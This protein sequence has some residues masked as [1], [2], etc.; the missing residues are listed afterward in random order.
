MKLV[1][2]SLVV[3]LSA[4][5]LAHC[6]LTSEAI[7]ITEGFSPSDAGGSP[8]ARGW[9]TTGFTNIFSWN[10][11]SQYLDVF[12]DSSKQNS[13]FYHP[14]GTT[15]T[16]T[17][18]FSVAFDFTLLSIG[19]HPEKPFSFQLALGFINLAQASSSGYLR[20]SGYES[21]NLAEFTYFADT[22]FGASVTPVMIDQA[23]NYALGTNFLFEFVLGQ[24]YHVEMSYAGENRTLTTAI[25]Q[26]G[27]NVF[28]DSIDLMTKTNFTDVSLDT[29]AI[30][31][32]NDGNQF[33]GFEGSL[34]AHSIID[35]ITLTTPAPAVGTIHL[36][37]VGGNVVATVFC[38]P[39]LNY[40]LQR[41]TDFTGWAD[42]DSAQAISSN[43]SLS[44]TNAPSAA[45]FYRVKKP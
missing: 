40:T 42:V 13:F 26:N 16:R 19:Q 23:H 8:F 29:F 28:N 27:T 36:N 6:P 32:Y 2:S 38:Q 15:V 7:T 35:N 39:G 22:G 44:D 30:S 20:G 17:N 41:T 31:S 4:I 24:Q 3:A 33:P 14:L 5:T 11:N 18:D 9:K 43:L 34:L 1:R 37:K 12:W 10:T 25:K 21:P 45:A